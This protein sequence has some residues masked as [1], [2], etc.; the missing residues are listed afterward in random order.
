MKQFRTIR[1]RAEKRKGG[2]A[3]LKKLLPVVATKKKLS[4][5]GDDRFLAM[6]TKVIN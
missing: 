5:L 6:M 1:A 3:A 2:A 4:A